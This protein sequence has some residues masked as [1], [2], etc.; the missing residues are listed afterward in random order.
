MA[1]EFFGVG[2]AAL[3]RLLA[4]LVDLLALR[5]QSVAVDTL[6]GIIPD[7]ANQPL[8]ELALLVH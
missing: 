8:V 6:L 1:V 4:S 3:D 5:C 2:K 7:V